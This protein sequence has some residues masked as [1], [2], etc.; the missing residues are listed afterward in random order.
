MLW[1]SAY[2]L[3]LTRAVAG[4]ISSV[5]CSDFWLTSKSGGN[6]GYDRPT[7]VGRAMKELGV[8]MIPSYAPQSR[9]RSLTACPRHLLSGLLTPPT[10]LKDGE[11]DLKLTP[12][13]IQV[14]TWL[15]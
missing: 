14:R 13:H 7:Q 9:G 4:Y 8:Q 15:R 10:I 1:T 11:F 12:V 5:S 6:V 3:S 2:S